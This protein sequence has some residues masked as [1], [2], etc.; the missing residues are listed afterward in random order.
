MNPSKLAQRDGARVF[1]SNG[2]TVVIITGWKPRDCEM[3][4]VVERNGRLLLC[5]K[6]PNDL[7]SRPG[8]MDRYFLVQP[9]ETRVSSRE[10]RLR[11]AEG[12]DCLKIESFPRGGPRP[13][14][15]CVFGVSQ[16]F[17]LEAAFKDALSRLDP[18]SLRQVGL[19]EV[20]S[21]GALYGGF[22]GFS[23]LFV[24]IDARAC[25]LRNGKDKI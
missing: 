23:R 20:V 11:H 22:S 25:N 12:S 5:N 13:S 19:V 1:E 14:D 17:S 3:P 15:R 24:S 4:E 21:M 16:D 8:S 2:Q 6:G 18:A 10:V 7:R 9:L